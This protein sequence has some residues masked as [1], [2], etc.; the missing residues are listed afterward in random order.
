MFSRKK[1]ES[2][3]A[4]ALV[5]QTSAGKEKTGEIGSNTAVNKEKKPK[6]DRSE[7]DIS[8]GYIKLNQEGAA[9]YREL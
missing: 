3:P 5:A 1:E 6:K 2:K 4:D 9:K 8:T 7:E